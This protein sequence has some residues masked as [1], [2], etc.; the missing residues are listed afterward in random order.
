MTSVNISESQSGALQDDRQNLM[1]SN[2]CGIWISEHL[3]MCHLSSVFLV[4]HRSTELL[5][6]FFK[7]AFAGLENETGSR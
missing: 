7:W 4:I 5:L 3:M 2:T 1:V 6:N